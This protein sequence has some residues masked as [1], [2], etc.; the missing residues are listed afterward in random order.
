MSKVRFEL[1]T[2]E[3]DLINSA[4]SLAIDRVSG[5][6]KRSSLPAV[7][8]AVERSLHDFRQVQRIFAD[9]VSGQ[10]PLVK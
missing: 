7:A 9:A 2:V 10:K 4:I 3:C 5:S 1:D 6:A 8:V